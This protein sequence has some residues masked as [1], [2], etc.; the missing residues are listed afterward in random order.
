MLFLIMAAAEFDTKKKGYR[1]VHIFLTPEEAA[2]I[3]YG[4]SLYGKKSLK[5]SVTLN[6]VYESIGLK[7][8]VRWFSSKI[9]IAVHSGESSLTLNDKHLALNIC[10]L[11]VR[12][13]ELVLHNVKI[14]DFEFLV[15]IGRRVNFR[16]WPI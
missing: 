13:F 6:E 7:L 2:S 5:T 9:V 16:M 12:C 15:E 4:L 10:D 3:G 11:E 1:G 14:R 8:P